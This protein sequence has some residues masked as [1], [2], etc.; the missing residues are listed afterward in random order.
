[1]RLG[2][3]G[4]HGLWVFIVVVAFLV[5]LFSV[6]FAVVVVLGVVVVVTIVVCGA[7]DDIGTELVD[8]MGKQLLK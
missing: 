6:T 5:V 7:E 2:L 4:G 1:L 8:V 3:T